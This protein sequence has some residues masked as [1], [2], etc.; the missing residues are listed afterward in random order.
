MSAESSSFSAWFFDRSP[1]MQETNF[2]NTTISYYNKG[3]LLGMLL[4]LEI[5]SRTQG[6][7][8]LLDALRLMY[9]E[10][11]QAPATSYYRPGRG[12]EERDVVEA[13]N[14]VTGTDFAPFFA[15]YVSGTDDLPYQETL[16]IGG[17]QLRTATAPDAA[18][19]LGI[20]AQPESRG[21]RILA[22]LPGGAADRAGLSRD[23]L[24]IAVDGQSLASEDLAT[25]LKPYRVG[26]SVPMDV[27]RHGRR[28]RITVTL[29]PPMR[30]Q[31]SIV[32]LP[33]A[34]PEQVAIREVWL[35]GH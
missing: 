4:D 11:Y 9:H 14:S 20:L 1:Q 15:R 32:P 6:R 33:S 21:T 5:R 28:E 17:L 35:A 30:N 13:L 7:K 24:V 22:I 8:S 31:Y 18:P 16:A 34:T 23:D 19:S 3:A 12:Y 29:D 10:F 26:A 2:A 25:R 27:E